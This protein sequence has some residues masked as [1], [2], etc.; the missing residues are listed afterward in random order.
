MPSASTSRRAASRRPWS[1]SPA[2]S[3]RAK[4]LDL[5]PPGPDERLRT[6]SARWPNGFRGKTNGRA[7]SASGLPCPAPSTSRS[8]SFVGPTTLEG[9]RGVAVAERLSQG[10]RACRLRRSRRCRRGPG[11]EPLWRGRAMFRDFYYL[12]FGVGLGGSHGAG[13]RALRGFARQCRRDRP[14]A[15]GAGWRALFLRQPRLPR[16]LCLARSLS[17]AARRVIGRDG[18]IAE[19]APLLRNA[20]VTIENLFDPETIVIGGIWL[21]T[22]L[23]RRTHRRRRAAAHLG[24]RPQADRA[25]PRIMRSGSGP[26]RGAARRGLARLL[27]RAV[28]AL[29]HRVRGGRP[30]TKDPLFAR[31][32]VA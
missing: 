21:T 3:W 11:R 22:D 16:T 20:I 31:S 24:R 18:W 8:M 4:R 26:G 13:R 6:R 17:D 23:L 1:T 29:R 9:W 32:R 30:P 2:P 12:Y 10:H 7:C 25:A 14:C 19:A 28:A 5:S 27:G 15:A